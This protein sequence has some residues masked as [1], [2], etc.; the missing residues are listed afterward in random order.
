MRGG[1]R[2]LRDPRH[3]TVEVRLDA[4][5]PAC[6]AHRRAGGSAPGGDAAL[7]QPVG[8]AGV[9][10]VL[11][12]AVRLRTARRQRED[13]QQDGQRPQANPR[14]PRTVDGRTHSA[15]VTGSRR[16]LG[17][18]PMVRRDAQCG[19]LQARGFLGRQSAGANRL[20]QRCRDLRALHR[21]GDRRR[22]A[23]AACWDG[24]RPA[25]ARDCSCARARASTRSSCATRSRS[26]SS[27]RTAACC[28][29]CRGSRRGAR[30]RSAARGRC[31]SWRRGR[32]RGSGSSPA[33]VSSSPPVATP[34][35]QSRGRG[36][37]RRAARATPTQPPGALRHTRGTTTPGATS[38]ASRS[39]P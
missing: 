10:L 21:R 31:S 9:P 7:E 8:G 1:Q 16:K 36:C 22:S 6:S 29:S 17:T 33:T 34:A 35:R 20:W 23:C 26:C 2:A 37:A 28:V 13:H 14:Q 11:V 18:C 12:A 3:A 39:S 27:A 5:A 15:M 24:L 19:T 32:A 4:Q 25:P 38:S 30:R